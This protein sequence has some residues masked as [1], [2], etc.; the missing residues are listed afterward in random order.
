MKKTIL[1]A[2]F[3]LFIS[4]A[5]KAQFDIGQRVISGGISLSSSNSTSTINSSQ[6]GFSV[7][8]SG[9]LGKFVRANH[10]VG[11][12]IGYTNSYLSQQSSPDSY[13]NNSNQIG[14]NYFSSYYKTIAKNFYG[15]I[16]W[17]ASG[18]YGYSSYNSTLSGVESTRKSNS[19]SIGISAIPGITYKLNK[20]VLFNA[21]LNNILSASFTSSKTTY[22]NSTQ[23]DKGN[24]FYLSSSLSGGSLGNIGLG[25]SILL[26]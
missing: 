4:F 17:S 13:K 24:G 9:S 5:S 22:S 14:L 25:F 20:R 10:L 6:T 16:T 21:T 3:A 26:N 2:T 19:I 15:F 11:F 18:Y 23:V 12:G 1:L 7:G 8:L